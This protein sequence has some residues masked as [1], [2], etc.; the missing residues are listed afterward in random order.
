[1]ND[2]HSRRAD[3]FLFKDGVRG[4]RP[5]IVCSCMYSPSSKDMCDSCVILSQKWIAM[6]NKC[7][8]PDHK[9]NFQEFAILKQFIHPKQSFTSNDKICWNCLDNIRKQNKALDICLFCN[10]RSCDCSNGHIRY[11]SEIV[12]IGFEGHT[13]SG[14]KTIS[15]PGGKAE[16]MQ[17]SST[18]LFITFEGPSELEKFIVDK[19]M[20]EPHISIQVGNT[21]LHHGKVFSKDDDSA[22]EQLQQNLRDFKEAC[23]NIF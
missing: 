12:Q 13:E 9:E 7:E 16:V 5:R 3:F 17:K 15:T 2:L 6:V 11:A 14:W 22:E 19:K 20:L 23:S 10:T 1:M 21:V 4:G 18:T 8:H